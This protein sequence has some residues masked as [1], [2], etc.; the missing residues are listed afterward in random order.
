[1]PDDAVGGGRGGGGHSRPR[2]AHDDRR[3]AAGILPPMNGRLAGRIAP[4]LAGAIGAALLAAWLWRLRSVGGAFLPALSIAVFLFALARPT[5]ALVLV[6]AILPLTP[7]SA[8]LLRGPAI[9]WGEIAWLAAASG[10]LLA[11]AGE[12]RAAAPGVFA[13]G[14]FVL[15]A[16]LDAFSAVAPYLPPGVAARLGGHLLASAPELLDATSPFAPVRAVVV[17]FE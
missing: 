3:A 17:L 15:W 11:P 5:R 6:I 2:R 7:I 14:L 4:V 12:K 13:F 10:S 9:S 8:Y 1:M 16:A